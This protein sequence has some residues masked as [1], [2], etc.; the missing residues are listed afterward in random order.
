ML[1]AVVVWP[2]N[3]RRVMQ[4]LGIVPSFICVFHVVGH[5]QEANGGANV[6]DGCDIQLC[7]AFHVI[8]L[9]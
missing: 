2:R 9:M 1:A 8:F 6:F 5:Y 3:V 7:F 4:A